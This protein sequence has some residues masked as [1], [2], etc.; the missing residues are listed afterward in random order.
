MAN[1]ERTVSELVLSARFAGEFSLEDR[2]GDQFAPKSKKS[3]CILA[4]CLYHAGDSIQRETLAHLCW[5][6]RQREQGLGSLRQAI[7]DIKLS[8]GDHAKKVLEVGRDYVLVHS[9]AI[10]NDLSDVTDGLELSGETRFLGGLDFVSPT[11]DDWLRQERQGIVL[12]AQREAEKALGAAAP[13]SDQALNAALRILELEP[14]NEG[15]ARAAM[16][17]YA[18]RGENSKAAAVYRNLEEG[19]RELGFDV[20]DATASLFEKL[21]SGSVPASAAGS[22]P[23]DIR[24]G[25]P[26]LVI[27]PILASGAGPGL[28]E[29]QQRLNIEL[30]ARAAEIREWR[31]VYHGAAI[32]GDAR[33]DGSYGHDQDNQGEYAVGGSV[34]FNGENYY[35]IFQ[36][37]QLGSGE[38]LR[39]IRTET[40]TDTPHESALEAV[41]NVV[42]AALPVIERMETGQILGLPEDNWT[43]YQ[44]YI[45]AK[46]I[47]VAS[48][49]TDYMERAE[50]YLERSIELD[51][52]FTPPY[53]YLI[54]SYNSGRKMTSPGLS[55]RK[56]TSRAMALCR[57]F[58][59]KDAQNPN[60]H[61]SMAWCLLRLRKFDEAEEYLD[62]AVRLKLYDPNRI[63]AL[64]TAFVY[65]GDSEKG[66]HY[67]D[68]AKKRML[69]NL[70]FMSTDY[71]EAHFF[72]HDFEK[73]IGYLDIEE[74]RN[75]LRT[76]ILRCAT[77][78]QL[79]R[80]VEAR[81]A[82]EKSINLIRARWQGRDPFSPRSAV[83]WYVDGYPLRRNEDMATL[84]EGLAKGGFVF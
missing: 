53:S 84:V 50:P 23:S 63:N 66:L 33:T 32:S 16:E 43:A 29:F 62:G 44:C 67:Y 25:A 6:D 54:G 4:Y 76:N 31:S 7:R 68:V 20:S 57:Q 70:D 11:F 8:L 48:T 39:T 42:T 59:M 5:P 37:F 56:G 47:I 55:R 18:A 65:L 24:G 58:L 14:E 72:R 77:L 49:D 26:R 74:L 12:R 35:G 45:Q 79:G 34:L 71:G 46:D 3:R 69:H 19:L 30:Q 1:I 60:A 82:A 22:I 51:P 80:L 64:A 41:E 40:P 10:E 13:H 38:L 27:N 81:A 9:H 83:K 61:L 2:N 28:Q 73:A 36:I 21:R 78:G 75:P 17:G 15:A 52:D